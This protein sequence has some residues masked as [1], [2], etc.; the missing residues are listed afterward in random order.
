MSIKH[1]CI[2]NKSVVYKTYNELYK[3]RLLPFLTHKWQQYLSLHTH[4]RQTTSHMSDLSPDSV[5]LVLHY[6]VHTQDQE[7]IPREILC[8]EC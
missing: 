8:E 4:K 6:T 1:K 2:F 5:N 3:I 7:Y